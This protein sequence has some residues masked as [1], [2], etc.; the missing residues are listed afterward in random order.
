MSIHDQLLYCE[1][2]FGFVGWFE[3]ESTKRLRRA[4]GFN[5]VIIRRR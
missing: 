5:N 3:R 4:Y 2:A 1:I